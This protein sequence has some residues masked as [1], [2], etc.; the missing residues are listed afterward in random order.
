MANRH[1]IRHAFR[2]PRMF[3]RRRQ[4]VRWVSEVWLSEQ[5]SLNR[6]DLNSFQ[7]LKSDDWY[8]SA[9]LLKNQTIL[10][11]VVVE[12]CPE[13]YGIPQDTFRRPI[14]MS[15]LW[16][17]WVVDADDVDLSSIKTAIRGSPIQSARVLQTGVWGAEVQMVPD[18]NVVQNGRIIPF[19]NMSVDWRGSA[20]VGPD[21]LVVFSVSEHHWQQEG[22]SFVDAEFQGSLSGWSRCLIK[23]P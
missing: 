7:L 20:K 19:P 12:L 11:R 10:K 16:M 18:E 21:D 22:D 17:L 1:P 4:A 13:F 2:R 14:G 3:G 15:L 9:T 6:L 8:P 5:I 23:R